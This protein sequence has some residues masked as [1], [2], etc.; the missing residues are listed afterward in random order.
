M[1]KF[2]TFALHLRTGL[3]LALLVTAAAGC[4]SNRWGFPY[5]A[6]VQQGNWITKDQVS[7]LRPGMTREQVRYA[8]GTPML[9]S[10]LHGNRWDYPYYYRAGTGK[11]EERTFTIFFDGAQLESWRGEEQPEIQPFQIAR[12]EVRTVVREDKQIKLD[13]ERM[14]ND[15]SAAV[16][17]IPGVS[18]D[19]M[20]TSG[21][22]LSDPQALPGAP[23]DAPVQ[24]R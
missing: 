2:H 15:G 22:P 10:A 23:E 13:N 1:V 11:I 21:P 6:S 20:Q 3:A 16:Q 14:N 4:S 7:L 24:L 18:I 5:K 12:E 17:L 19:Q 9:T 8:L